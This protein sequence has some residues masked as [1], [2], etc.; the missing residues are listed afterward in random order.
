MKKFFTLW[1]TLILT[2]LTLITQANNKTK[3]SIS[4][5]YSHNINNFHLQD[6]E[7][8]QHYIY[9]KRY[10]DTII[11]KKNELKKFYNSNFCN[12]KKERK[13]FEYN[14]FRELLY[15]KKL[16]SYAITISQTINTY[17]KKK[18]KISP[19]LIIKSIIYQNHFPNFYISDPDQSNQKIKQEFNYF[20][21][22]NYKKFPYLFN[23]VCKKNIRFAKGVKNL[24]QKII[25]LSSNYNKLDLS[26]ELSK[27]NDIIFL[28][29]LFFK[30]SLNEYSLYKNTLFFCFT[31]QEKIYQ[32]GR[33]S[34]YLSPKISL[35]YYNKNHSN[36]I[37]NIFWY[38]EKNKNT[39]Q[40]NH[41]L[42]NNQKKFSL[43]RLND[44]I[45][46]YYNKK[47]NFNFDKS[48]FSSNIFIS[49]KNY[50]NYK[51]KLNYRDN[52]KNFT[53]KEIELSIIS[54]YEGEFFPNK[55][56]QKSIHTFNIGYIYEK[57]APGHLSLNSEYSWNFMNDYQL[58]INKSNRYPLYKIKDNINS[59]SIKIPFI[60]KNYSIHLLKNINSVDNCHFIIGLNL[61]YAF[62]N[63]N[64]WEKKYKNILLSGITDLHLSQINAESINTIWK[65]EFFK[66]MNVSFNISCI[67]NL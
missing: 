26:F 11:N 34:I 31:Y 39:Q 4:Y 36:Q 54:K 16:D 30:N 5:S 41:L 9:N 44:I 64:I 10:L 55:F 56:L 63:F 29:N 37:N 59:D 18:V 65:K 6:K 33:Y 20:Y 35:E 38:N 60:H 8:K 25:D 52:Y 23:N 14:V 40:N 53:L 49:K 12:Q 1:P 48:N 27:K 7:I 15:K 42:N 50:L 66:I 47:D 51:Q 13:I 17:S 21:K 58:I 32:K 45:N 57:N 67:I 28:F 19:Y 46:E 24:I 3:F 62:A 43:L 2:F 61:Y 22:E